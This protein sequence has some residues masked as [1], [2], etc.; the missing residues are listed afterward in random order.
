MACS[1]VCASFSL[2]PPSVLS[3][4]KHI[5]FVPYVRFSP[6]MPI[7]SLFAI[8]QGIPMTTHSNSAISIFFSASHISY[9]SPVYFIFDAA[10]SALQVHLLLRSQSDQVSQQFGLRR[11]YSQKKSAAARK[12]GGGVD[13]G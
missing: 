8:Y 4:G 11:C 2:P 5:L 13:S 10:G 12:E 9:F 3:C 7:Q 1:F 6:K